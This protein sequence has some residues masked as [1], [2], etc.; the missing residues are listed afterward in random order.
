MSAGLAQ[1]MA[2]VS[3]ST[4]IVVVAVVVLK[5]VV[6]LGVKLAES[7]WSSPALSITP[8]PGSYSKLPATARVTPSTVKD[9]FASSC[10]GESTVP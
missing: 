5:S 7:V 9:A 10:V 4:L 1:V 3:W 6:S 2:G 8:T